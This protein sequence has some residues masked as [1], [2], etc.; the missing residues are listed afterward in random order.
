[1]KDL[2]MQQFGRLLALMPYGK[3]KWGHVLFL[4]ANA[5]KHQSCPNKP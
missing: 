4:F 5:E 1:M 2:S 3:N